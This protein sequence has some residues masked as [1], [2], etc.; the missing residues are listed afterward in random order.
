MEESCFLAC[1]RWLAQPSL[2]GANIPEHCW[3][4]DNS[5]HSAVPG[6]TSEFEVETINL[7]LG[8]VWLHSAQVIVMCI[9]LIEDEVFLWSIILYIYIILIYNI[10]YVIAW[11][12]SYIMCYFS[13]FFYYFWILYPIDIPYFIIF[14]RSKHSISL[15]TKQKLYDKY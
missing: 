10:Y 9:V 6:K 5:D 2:K 7:C 14:K 12:H 4:S 11:L 8:I 15:I 3:V 1:S 13:D